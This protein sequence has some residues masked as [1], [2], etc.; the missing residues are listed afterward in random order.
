MTASTPARASRGLLA[1]AFGLLLALALAAPALAQG[2]FGVSVRKK[3][4]FN[5][6]SQIRG[7]F[8]METYNNP[9]GLAS[10]T[11]L[12]DG[13]PLQT[14]DAAPFAITFAT[15]DYPDGWHELSAVGR[16]TAGES[17]TAPAQRFQFISS[18]EQGGAMARILLPLFAGIGLVF[19]LVVGFQVLISG[20]G[21]HEPL[22]AGAPRNY[23]LKGGAICP[24]C[25]RPFGL[26]IWSLN[27]VTGV[28]DRCDH[29][30]RVGFFRRAGRDALAAAERAELEGAAPASP[31]PTLSEED[32]LR[33]QIE[34]SKYTDRR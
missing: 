16:T 18:A 21:N 10:V 4:G 9:P 27:L 25:K 2:D 7:T 22:P 19:L 5:S 32:K 14:V 30:G 6:G 34:D 1:A 13:Q 15:T 28:V 29:C 26:H 3:M 23:G 20:R 31:P 12:I 17:V 24:R 33:Q 11:F 8:S